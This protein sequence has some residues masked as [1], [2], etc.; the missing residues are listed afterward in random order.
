MSLSRRF[1]GREGWEL[2][3]WV[4]CLV[5]EGLRPNTQHGDNRVGTANSSPARGA[6]SGPGCCGE[7]VL[8]ALRTLVSKVEVWAPHRE[9]LARGPAATNRRVGARSNRGFGRG[10]VPSTY[11]RTSN[12]ST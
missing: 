12:S 2:G 9:R 6:E 3:S 10:F 4:L 5:L 11:T 7:A 8:A 1:F